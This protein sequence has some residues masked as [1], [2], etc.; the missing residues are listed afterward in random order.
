M[1]IF[2]IYTDKVASVLKRLEA[3][4]ALP[5]EL[6]H[7]RVVVEPPRD[8]SHGDLATNA[9]M[10]LAKDARMNPRQLAELIVAELAA[11]P[12]VA[13]VSVAGPGFINLT[14]PASTY[15]DV[16]RA[17]LAAGA[18]FGRGRDRGLP[19]VN[20]E[21]VSAN[22]TGP[23]HVGHGRGAV[24][25]DALAGLLEFA[26][27]KV[28]ASTISTTPARRSTFSPAPPSCAT[29]R[30]GRG[31]RRDSGRAL[32]GDYLKAVGQ[33]LAKV[34]GGK[35]KSLPEAEWLPEVRRYAIDA[36][37]A[38]IRED[39]AALNVSHAVFFSER[40]LQAAGQGGEVA[41]AIDALRARAA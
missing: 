19:A 18:D 26:G 23:M 34:H 37:M 33:G 5:A 25:G 31:D 41:G 24:F 29:G 1:N 2:E 16:T 15:E 4:G 6:D 12:A 28:R 30:R 35:L 11:D 13:S 10:A 14:L 3:R 40:S 39:L 38:M 32:P 7:S 8:P 36:M 20:V 27:R 21:Y 9:A 17:V 22:P